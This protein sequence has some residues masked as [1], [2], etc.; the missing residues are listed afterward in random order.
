MNYIAILII[1]IIII[2]IIMEILLSMYRNHR[3]SKYYNESLK[4]SKEM[5]KKL[6]VIGNP[7]TGFWNRNVEKAY[8][9]GDLCLDIMGCDCANQIQGD[10]LN[11]LKKMESD[12]FI[13][14]ESCVLEYID[15]KDI[16]EVK[17]ELDRV[18]GGN[19]YGVRIFPNIFPLKS[20]FIEIGKV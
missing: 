11:E 17:N 2:I 6:L 18:S 20:K 3:R 8:D 4:L 5:D 7:T 9:C 1:I 19:Y 12:S 10:L 13:I 15:Q 14:Y 16:P